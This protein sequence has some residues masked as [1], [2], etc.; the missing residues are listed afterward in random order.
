MT[1]LQLH[2]AHR[3]AEGVHRTTVVQAGVS[4]CQVEHLQFGLPLHVC[5]F[6]SGR[7]CTS[8]D[9]LL[10]QILV[11]Q[12]RSQVWVLEFKGPAHLPRCFQ[13]RG[14]MRPLHRC[15]ITLV[16]SEVKLQAL[17]KM[18]KDLAVLP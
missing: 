17:I 11:Q 16:V 10:E 8:E 4:L 12:V 15:G 5:D 7:F 2:V 3:G 18:I 9:L 6:I 14:L 1:D 13:I